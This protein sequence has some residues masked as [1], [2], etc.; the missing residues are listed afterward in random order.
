VPTRANCCV[1][2]YSQPRCIPHTISA[3]ALRAPCTLSRS[4]TYSAFP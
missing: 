2:R 3:S 1:A 4:E